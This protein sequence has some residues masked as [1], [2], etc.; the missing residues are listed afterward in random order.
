[1][2]SRGQSFALLPRSTTNVQQTIHRR[3]CPSKQS[4]VAPD[5]VGS[6]TWDAVERG[7][8]P[9]CHPDTRGVISDSLVVWPNARRDSVRWISG[10]AGT[11]KTTIA[12]TMAEYWARQGLLVGSFFFSRSA[13]LWH[14][15]QVGASS[16]HS[17][18]HWDD[19]IISLSRTS[20]IPP[21][22]V[23]IIDGLDEYNKN[24]DQ[25]RFLRGVLRSFCQRNCSIKL[26]ISCRPERHLEDVFNEFRPHLGSSYRI[27]LGQ[28]AGDNDDIRTFLRIKLDEICRRHRK[29]KVMSIKDGPWPSDED[30]EMLVDSASGQFIFAATAIAFIEGEDKDPVELLNLILGHQLRSFGSIDALYLVILNR[31]AP[32]GSPYRQLTHQILFHINHEPSPAFDIGEFCFV[33]ETTIDIRI[34]HLRSVLVRQASHDPESQELIQFRH[35]SFH[36]FF[37]QPSSPHE[38]SLAALNPVTKFFYHLRRAAKIAHSRMNLQRFMHKCRSPQWLCY[39]FLYWDDHPPMILPYEEE[40]RRLHQKYAKRVP[41]F[42]GCECILRLDD[43]IDIGAFNTTALK[44]CGQDHCMMDAE[45]AALCHAISM[46]VKRKP[47][48][49]IE[50]W[51]EWENRHPIPMKILEF[52]LCLRAVLRGLFHPLYALGAFNLEFK[53]LI[54]D[55]QHVV[56]SVFSPAVWNF[57]V[58]IVNVFLCIGVYGTARWDLFLTHY[59]SYLVV[60][61]LLRL[62]FHFTLH[63]TS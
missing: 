27:Q 57:C 11:G 35:K 2:G 56:P 24:D 8:P 5:I 31:V 10:W 50:R 7:D 53:D 34:K 37:A 28:S 36:D 17:Q 46:T 14:P 13:V 40:A 54:R 44:L 42:R 16:G 47:D 63:S 22:K 30:I 49:F 52:F 1:M 4:L 33:D 9:K 21:F 39:S 18:R 59:A 3:P 26:L 19:W 55:A 41:E 23:I 48:H 32:A 20:Q 45:L 6:A 38:F 51:E 58:A 61:G 62:L 25:I 60:N 43:G 12:Q 15:S 29:S